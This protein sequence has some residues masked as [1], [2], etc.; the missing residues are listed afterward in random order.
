MKIKVFDDDDRP[1]H[2]MK[3]RSKK[4]RSKMDDIF[5]KFE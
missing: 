4:L 5:K 1:I 2:K 3:G